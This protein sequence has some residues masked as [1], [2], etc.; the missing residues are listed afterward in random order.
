[1]FRSKS[2]SI[3]AMGSSLGRT[4]SLNGGL[5][6]DDVYVTDTR[7]RS[8]SYGT[9]YTCHYKG[10]TQQEQKNNNATTTH[11]NNNKN[12]PT[13]YAVKI[14]DR[15]KIKKKDDEGTLREVRILQEFIG[16]P[17]IIQLLDFFIEPER[18]LVVQNYAAGGDVFDRLA[19][20]TTYSEHDA[21]I[22]AKVLLQAIH[23][24]HAVKPSPVVH[25][26]L[27][28]ENLLLASQ[29][30]NASILV[31]DFGFARHVPD[32]KPTC[33]TRCGTVRCLSCIRTDGQPCVCVCVCI[34]LALSLSYCFYFS[35]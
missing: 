26:D 3:P 17:N 33:K 13:E 27:K 4:R 14:I 32:G 22:L 2:P 7:L 24:M 10:E 31:A 23:A 34:V 20:R 9:V 8:G 21:R 12:K 25:R 11:N 29:V 18:Y 6:Y 1:M 5:K 15:T 28:P 35:L 19:A 16:V 30:D